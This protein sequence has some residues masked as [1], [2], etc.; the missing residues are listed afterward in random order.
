MI[1]LIGNATVDRKQTGF[2]K[3]RFSNQQ[4]QILPVIVAQDE[5]QQ[6]PASDAGSE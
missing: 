1:N 3:L 4:R 2:V 6:L 5:T